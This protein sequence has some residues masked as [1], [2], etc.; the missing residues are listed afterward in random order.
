MFGGF[1]ILRFSALFAFLA[2]T[3][4]PAH[5]LVATPQGTTGGPHWQ[6][7]EGDGYDWSWTARNSNWN[8][9]SNSNTNS[10]SNSNFNSNAN[11]NSSSSSRSENSSIAFSYIDS[12][13][14]SQSYTHFE[15]HSYQS[16]DPC[17]VSQVPVPA[18][19][20]LFLSALGLLG[21]GRLVRKRRP[22]A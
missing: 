21:I 1:R 9:N 11:S 2:G 7:S 20:P 13:S 10:N 12:Q 6:D 22:A 17:I 19:L 3:P 18:A 14:Q 15:S 16:G 5:A 4:I 8:S